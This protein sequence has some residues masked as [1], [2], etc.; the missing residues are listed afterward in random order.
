MTHP[1]L[2][3]VFAVV[4][5]VSSSLR[6]DPSGLEALQALQ[7]AY[8]DITSFTAE[9][10]QTSEQVAFGRHVTATGA[11]RYA[12]GNMRWDYR[13]P[14]PQTFVIAGGM[15]RWFQPSEAQV[16][17]LPAAQAF[18]SEAAIA[19]LL[20]GMADIDRYFTLRSTQDLG[21]GVVALV[22]LPKFNNPQVIGVTIEFDRAAGFARAVITEDAFGNI[23]RIVFAEVRKNEPVSAD[24]FAPA[25]PAGW[26]V[27]RMPAATVAPAP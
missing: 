11:I 5:G 2:W 9:F 18:E 24:V 10:V 23:N 3:F 25:A 4:L 22:M 19:A 14:Q 15:V 17:E 20:G 16:V 1:W 12:R 6:A 26:H 8:R 27:W 7:A 21:A 13:E